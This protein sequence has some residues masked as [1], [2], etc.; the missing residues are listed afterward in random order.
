M[1]TATDSK[2][3]RATRVGFRLLAGRDLDGRTRT[4]ARWAKP[5]TQAT[6]PHGHASR[7]A[8]YHHR[9]RSGI[10]LTALT[11]SLLV[12][13]GWVT[14]W[15][16]TNSTLRVAAWLAILT[17][18][19]ATWEKGRRY[20][21]RRELIAPLG[22]T[23]AA[24]FG[25]SKYMLD[26]R[27]WIDVPVDFEDRPTTIYLP[28]TYNPTEAQEKT[29][30][31]LVGRRIGLS[32]PTSTFDLRGERPFMELRPAPAP[33]DLVAFSDPA[34]RAMVEAA[35]EGRPM[36][37]LA[38]RDVPYGLDLDAEAPH[39][40]FSMATNAGKS[41]AARA[42]L[43]QQLHQGG[44]ALILDRKQV[45]HAWCRDHPGV[46]YCSSER[47][48]YD[49]LI[50]LS[51]EIDRRFMIVKNNADIRGNVDAA[52]IGPRLT[53]IAE[54]LNTLQDDISTYWRT[55]RPT[56]APMKPPAM[57]ALG[58]SMAMGRQGRVHVIPIGQKI[59]AQA[60]GGTA[61]RENMSTRVLGRAT[62]STWNMLAPECKRGGRYPRYTKHRGRVYVV[63]GDEATPVQVIL[64]D[65][66]EAL[67]YALAGTVAVFPV[68]DGE[69]GAASTTTITRDNTGASGELP[70]LMLVPP[71]PSEAVSLSDA[72][73]RLGLTIKTVRN[74]RDR[75][76]RFPDPVSSGA[77][78]PSLYRWEDIKK[79]NGGR[80][81]SVLDGAS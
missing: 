76:S 9:R 79:W 67:D 73:E 20:V 32:H 47:E 28:K 36:L 31:R 50:W 39:V 23:L 41:T 34:I 72:A 22:E 1:A 10:R 74:G 3:K 68:V 80:T 35:P 38:P 12:G 25:D 58:R 59:T 62:T 70:H 54:E 69:A 65:E 60:I 57:S 61:A 27:S 45:S 55:I 18:L 30:A 5:G 71:P 48:I 6:T 26:R 81:A 33:P 7:W 40:G 14:D 17:G 46:R 29:L 19:W 64:A 44:L 21:H 8:H 53:V 51:A 66:Q 11:A 63:V 37:G 56:G 4:D 24:H 16:A 2:T 13:Y 15:G 77:G 43:M 75:D 49:A 42:L 78:K 52:L